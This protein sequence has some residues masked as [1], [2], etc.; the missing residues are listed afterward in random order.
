MILF[1]ISLG[2]HHPDENYHQQSG[3]QVDELST[4]FARLYEAINNRPD[5]PNVDKEEIWET[6]QKIE[7][8]SEKQGQANVSK[9]ERWV[10]YLS[11][12]APDIVDVI[13]ASLGGPVSGFT[14]VLKKIAQQAHTQTGEGTPSS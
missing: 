3:A 6:I 13:L 7:S 8:E 10:T 12:I 14:A 1:C 2:C 11:S 4:L 5:D 9:L